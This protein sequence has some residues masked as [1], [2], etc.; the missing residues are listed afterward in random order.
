MVH[1]FH[2]VRSACCRYVWHGPQAYST[3]HRGL[4]KVGARAARRRC[5]R[6][7]K[8]LA[9]FRLEPL[10]SL[11][12]RAHRPHRCTKR[13]HC[14]FDVW[15]IHS[16]LALFLLTQRPT[17]RIGCQCWLVQQS[18]RH[19]WASQPW[20]LPNRECR[21]TVPSEGTLFRC[22]TGAFASRAKKGPR[23]CRVPG[24]LRTQ[25]FSGSDWTLRNRC[26]SPAARRAFVVCPKRAAGF[27]AS[28]RTLRGPLSRPRETTQMRSHPRG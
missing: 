11:C 9:L 3:T 15:A 22:L 21:T 25:Y 23:K 1:R 19:A 16:S 5:C 2:W 13:L 27:H 28:G 6:L 26:G 8:S 24:G 18:W 7:D 20:R 12:H 10:R 17:D 14:V 4:C